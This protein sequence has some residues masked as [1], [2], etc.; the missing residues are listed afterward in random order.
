VFRLAV[1]GARQPR[2]K[3]PLGKSLAGGLQFVASYTY[4][5][6]MVSWIVVKFPCQKLALNGEAQKSQ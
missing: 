4:V 6:F 3:L 2:S 1:Q 5:E